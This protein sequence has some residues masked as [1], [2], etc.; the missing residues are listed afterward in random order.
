M[1]YQIQELTVISSTQ[2]RARLLWFT[3]NILVEIVDANGQLTVNEINGG[4]SFRLQGVLPAP[5]L[6]SD[7]H[8]ASGDYFVQDANDPSMLL[9]I[10]SVGLVQKTLPQ[11]A[12]YDVIHIV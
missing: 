10:G 3:K 6:L 5:N 1:F 11:L 8:D 7:F 4:K 12:D 9:S 2:S